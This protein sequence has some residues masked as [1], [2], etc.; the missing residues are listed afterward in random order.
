MGRM[1]LLGL[2]A[3]SILS[4]TCDPVGGACIYP[5]REFETIHISVRDRNF[6]CRKQK[7]L[8]SPLDIE[9]I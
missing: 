7:G 3:H 4:T 1:L 5:A 8:T 6:T 2:G 9:P